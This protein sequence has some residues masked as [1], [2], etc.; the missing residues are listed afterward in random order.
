LDI[1]THVFGIVVVP[2]LIDVET[3][4]L[5]R[6]FVVHCKSKHLQIS[7]EISVNVLSENDVPVVPISNHEYTQLTEPGSICNCIGAF[8]A[9]VPWSD[10]IVSPIAAATNAK[11]LI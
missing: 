3:I 10:R 11:T 4:T 7:K 5:N 6:L 9:F 2:L 8:C 1:V